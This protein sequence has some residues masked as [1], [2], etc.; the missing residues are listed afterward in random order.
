[1]RGADC[2]ARTR[3][4][5]VAGVEVPGDHATRSTP[6][7]TRSFAH[8]YLYE[9]IRWNVGV[10]FGLIALGATFVFKPW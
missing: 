5:A 3:G 9:P 4:Y 7:S 10:G 8:V 6:R 1:M 2:L